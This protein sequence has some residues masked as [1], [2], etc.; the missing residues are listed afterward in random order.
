LGLALALL[1]VLVM[2]LG[3]APL[4]DVDEGA[5]SE[6]TREMLVSGDWGHTTLNGADRFD[7]PIGVYWLQAISAQLWGLNEWAM[8]LPSALATWLAAMA[9]GYFVAPRWGWRAGALAAVVHVTSFGSWAMAHAATADA[10]LG[11]CLMLSALDLWRYMAN[12]DLS[13]LRRMALWV[14]LGLVIKGPVAVLLPAACLFLGALAER[15]WS[16][17]WR[18]L[19]DVRAWLILLVVAVPWYAYAVWRHGHAF[20]EGFILR[21][22]IDRF[23]APMEGHTGGWLYF[24]LVAPLLW[25]PWSPLLTVWWG[26]AGTLWRD[27]NIRPALI[28]AGFVFVFFSVSGTKLPHYGI[29]AAPGMVVLLVAGLSHLRAWHAG[30]CG[31]LLVLWQAVLVA[32]P[33]VWMAWPPVGV[34][35]V[36]SG[37]PWPGNAVAFLNSLWPVA[38]AWAA[39]ALAWQVWP[40]GLKRWGHEAVLASM[41]LLHVLVLTWLIWPWWGQALQGP[42]QS[43]AWA[44]R[45][46]PGAV[47]QVGGNWPSFAFYRQDAMVKNP[48][49]ADMLLMPAGRAASHSDRPLLAQE[50]G[51]VLLGKPAADV[52]P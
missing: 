3:R 52:K 46:W 25:M 7:K 51:M 21:H 28:W 33:V 6:A 45:A 29:Y 36:L 4:F 15:R 47:A 48:A 49:Q 42:I 18:A 12:G 5:F 8:R 17:V 27:A 40:S 19:A 41:A 30:L 14:G 44:A 20:I 39:L 22:N 50:Q 26:R 11:L 9:V 10:V 2:G 13:A 38:A 34:P 37:P 32:S 31:V 23:A 16:V 43:L 24:V 35:S 1:L